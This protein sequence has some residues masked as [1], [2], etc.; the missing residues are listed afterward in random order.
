MPTKEWME[1]YEAIKEKLTC[2]IDWML[3]S[4]KR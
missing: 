3:I 1:K 2:K 4:Q